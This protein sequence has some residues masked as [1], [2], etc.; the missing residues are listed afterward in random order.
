[1][2]L[3]HGFLFSVLCCSTACENDSWSSSEKE[4][5]LQGCID[6]GGSE[7]YCECFLEKTINHCPIAEEADKIDYET[8][9]GFASSCNE[10]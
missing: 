2:R 7:E 8:K 9:V 10:N 3:F 1:M 6:E 4:T 5:F